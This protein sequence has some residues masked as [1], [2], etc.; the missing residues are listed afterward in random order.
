MQ[1]PQREHWHRKKP[2]QRRGRHPGSLHIPA[3]KQPKVSTSWATDKMLTQEDC[4]GVQGWHTTPLP[5]SSPRSVSCTALQLLARCVP[6]LPAREWYPSNV[7]L[8]HRDSSSKK[9]SNQ[10]QIHL[11]L[12]ASLSQLGGRPGQTT[13]RSLLQ[14]GAF[15]HPGGSPSL[16]TQSHL[17][18][19]TT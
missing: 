19:L 12:P 1:L 5:S 17:T 16:S 13:G 10:P 7:Q 8:G 6:T 9:C 2:S 14:E 18:G 4:W 15:L 11:R 3:L